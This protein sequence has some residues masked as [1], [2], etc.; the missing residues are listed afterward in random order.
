VTELGNRS[1][2]WSLAV[3]DVPIGYG[4]D[5]VE[6]KKILNKMALDLQE[7]PK[8]TNR[9]MSDE[10]QV[11]V[12]SMTPTSVTVRIRI[13]TMHDQQLAVARELRVRAVAALDA[14][15]V[16]T[17]SGPGDPTPP[18]SPPAK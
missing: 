1:Q 17:F 16:P 3:V 4:A 13:H 18:T 8:W 14:A 10:P 5:L 2:G 15:G 7:D 6:A 12:E 9:V 11:A